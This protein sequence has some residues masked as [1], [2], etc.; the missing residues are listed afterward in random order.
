MILRPKAPN[1]TTKCEHVATKGKW[2]V[3]RSPG[4]LVPRTPR[5]GWGGCALSP[6]RGYGSAG[7]QTPGPGRGWNPHAGEEAPPRNG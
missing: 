1:N 4:R 5:R 6:E 3:K 7:M 2:A